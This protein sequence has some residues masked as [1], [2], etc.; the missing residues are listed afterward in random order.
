MPNPA[1]GRA[2]IRTSPNGVLGMAC[3]CTSA[4][5]LLARACIRTKSPKLISK[6]PKNGLKNSQNWSLSKIPKIGIRKMRIRP[7]PG[8]HPQRH[9]MDFLVPFFKHKCAD[10]TSEKRNKNPPNWS[11]DSPELV[12]PKM[13]SKISQNGKSI[14]RCTDAHPGGGVHSLMY[15]CT[16]WREVHSPSRI[17][18]NPSQ[19][20]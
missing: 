5:G 12:S 15:G 10:K 16:P 19:N 1:L 11:Q 6:I 3:I 17:F 7:P 8:V 4:N 13:V 14:R 20:A 9:R 18:H 2:C